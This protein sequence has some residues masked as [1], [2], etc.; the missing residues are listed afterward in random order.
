MASA[1]S[2]TQ[3]GTSQHGSKPS[4]NRRLEYA[5]ERAE[6]LFGSYRRGDANDPDR[7]V[8][9]IAAVLTLYDFELIRDVTDP[10]TGIQTTEKFCSFMPNAGEL[11]VYCDA[12][13]AQRDRIQKLAELPR[14]NFD[15]QALPP[16][17]P[18]PGDKATVFV[19]AGNPH[20]AALIEWAKRPDTDPRL[21]RFEQRPGIWV[22]WTI[23]D[24]RRTV[25]AAR[26]EPQPRKLQL[27]EEAQRAMAQVDAERTHGLPADR[28]SEEVG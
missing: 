13:A 15:R 11:K 1:Q 25:T 2:T 22:A 8:T 24:E 20:C 6:V 23:W 19:H 16:P 4:M 3:H 27:S 21:F 26:P 18:A 17:P 12:I 28:A 9:S 10:R 5:T 14:P 7:Y